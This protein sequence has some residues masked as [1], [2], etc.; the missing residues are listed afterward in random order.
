MLPSRHA[1]FRIGQILFQKGVRLILDS[2]AFGPN[3]L[4][5]PYDIS[6]LIACLILRRHSIVFPPINFSI[7]L[8]VDQALEI[9]NPTKSHLRLIDFVDDG[10][11]QNCS[12]HRECSKKVPATKD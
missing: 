6:A 2:P 9:Q 7:V 12:R 5:I 11:R 1:F 8:L 4:R 10:V 3:L